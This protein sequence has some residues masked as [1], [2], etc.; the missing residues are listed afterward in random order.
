MGAS[1][2]PIALHLISPVR[3]R[4]P[5]EGEVAVQAQSEPG[6]LG[7]W[8]V[9]SPDWKGHAMTWSPC[10][11][12]ATQQPRV[13]VR[14]KMPQQPEMVYLLSTNKL[15]TLP[16]PQQ[17]L[18]QGRAQHGGRMASGRSALGTPLLRRDF[19]V[20]HQLGSPGST[21][22][23]RTCHKPHL[24]RRK[25]PS[26]YPVII[27]WSF[28]RSGRSPPPLSDSPFGH[29]A[30]HPVTIVSVLWPLCSSPLAAHPA[31]IELHA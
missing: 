29:Q 22:P 19:S 1:A 15:P 30:S 2:E 20:I 7:G 8:G 14:S 17:G 9:H 4:R 16:G 3:K 6:L 24:P 5:G 18:S 10:G 11:D 13:L 28:A 25:C 26:G 23:I 31:L 12:G 21:Q 27:P